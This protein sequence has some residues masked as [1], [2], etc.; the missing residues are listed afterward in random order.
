MRFLLRT[1][2]WLGL[3][4]V[5]LPS[6]G[7]QPLPKAH[8][9]AGD[10]LGAARAAMSDLQQFC[11]RQPNACEVGSQ[12]ATTL[13]QRAQL[14]AKM[15]YEFL[16]QHF[17]AEENGVGTTGAVASSARP[18]TPPTGSQ[19]TLRPADLAPAWRGPPR[20]TARPRPS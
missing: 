15:L 8:V 17:G 20:E 14:G 16:Q 19:D 13:G 12:T 11:Q 4:L 5:L 6:G 1:A 10:A 18:G 9:S 7:S 2:F 3:V